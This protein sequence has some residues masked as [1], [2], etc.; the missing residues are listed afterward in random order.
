MVVGFTSTYAHDH[1]EFDTIHP[2]MTDVDI[3][4]RKAFSGY[5]IR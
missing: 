3:G 1:G 4:L 5:S 2:F